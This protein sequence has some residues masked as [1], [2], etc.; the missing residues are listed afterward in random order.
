MGDLGGNGWT[1]VAPEEEVTNIQNWCSPCCKCQSKKHQNKVSSVAEG[2]D[3]GM[4]CKLEGVRRACVEDCRGTSLI[5][6]L[7][8]T[9]ISQHD[10]NPELNVRFMKAYVLL[11]TLLESSIAAKDSPDGI[12]HNLDVRLRHV[13]GNRPEEVR[14]AGNSHTQAKHL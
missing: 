2:G 5:R 7:T 3:E 12:I 11:E 1:S 13:R 14:K 8:K 10:T 4:C 6:S 9:E